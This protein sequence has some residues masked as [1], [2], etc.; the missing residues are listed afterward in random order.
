MKGIKRSK[1]QMERR[2][3]QQAKAECCPQLLPKGQPLSGRTW[4]SPVSASGNL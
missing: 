1:S 2:A 3:Y 4:Q